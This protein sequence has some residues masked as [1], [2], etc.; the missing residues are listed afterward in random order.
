MAGNDHEAQRLANGS[1]LVL[2]S[3]RS[4]KESMGSGEYGQRLLQGP[5]LEMVV[6]VR[7]S[8]G[9]DYRR[10]PTLK[11]TSFQLYAGS[12]R[13]LSD[14][15]SV[16]AWK[17]SV[18]LQENHHHVSKRYKINLD[19]H[20][21]DWGR[22]DST[23]LSSNYQRD[24]VWT[25]DDRT[26]FADLCFPGSASPKCITS[27]PSDDEQ[28]NEV[29]RSLNGLSPPNPEDLNNDFVFTTE[30]LDDVA[31]GMYDSESDYVGT[32][33]TTSSTEVE[34]V[35]GDMC[36]DGLGIRVGFGSCGRIGTGRGKFLK[37]TSCVS[38]GLE[39]TQCEGFG[40]VCSYCDLC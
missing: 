22:G 5:E 30:F 17:S 9:C 40:Y 4:R 2:G 18:H 8:D 11:G 19:E 14:D 39:L 37:V 6:W 16:E 32:Q 35:S 3:N 28:W 36:D 26:T 20:G 1:L 31:R 24:P 23:I 7:R 33:S 13:S 12:T 34:E 21:V 25:G 38:C 10:L 27:S 29:L 15:G